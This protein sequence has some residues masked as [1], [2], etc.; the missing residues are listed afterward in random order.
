MVIRVL[1]PS[2]YFF[3]AFPFFATPSL[4]LTSKNICLLCKPASELHVKSQH[5]AMSKVLHLRPVAKRGRELRLDGHTLYFLYVRE[6][7]FTCDF[8]MKNQQ[9]IQSGNRILLFPGNQAAFLLA[10]VGQKN[11]R[12]LG[13]ETHEPCSYYATVYSSTSEKC[14]LIIIKLDLLR[15]KGQVED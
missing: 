11:H 9:C 13:T 5:S 10:A 14:P 4:Q 12:P 7:M 3:L 1:T 15:I 6:C 8:H 2:S